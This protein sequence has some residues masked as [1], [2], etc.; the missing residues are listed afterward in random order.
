MTA[1][2]PT[3][4]VTLTQLLADYD[5][6][7]YAID[8]FLGTGLPPRLA[9]VASLLAERDYDVTVATFAGETCISILRGDRL[10]LNLF[11]SLDD[12]I[13]SGFTHSEIVAAVVDLAVWLE[14]ETIR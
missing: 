8:N 3:T 10:L 5:Q 12:Y 7:S 11:S 14:S 4:D 1:E 6:N 2:D 13:F 9:G